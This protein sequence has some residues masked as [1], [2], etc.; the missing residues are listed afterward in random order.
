[1]RKN[2][3]NSWV[4]LGQALTIVCDAASRYDS[5]DIDKDLSDKISLAVKIAQ[6]VNQAGMIFMN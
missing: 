1:M 2:E 3:S 6:C 4:E 5:G